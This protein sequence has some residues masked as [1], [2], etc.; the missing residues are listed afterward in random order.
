VLG[1]LIHDLVYP[2]LL[3][4]G[5]F[6]PSFFVQFSN[7][8]FSDPFKGMDFP[9]GNYPQASLGVLVPLSEQNTIP[10]VLD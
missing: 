2:E 5:D 10:L 8:C 4:Y 6:E 3:A 1:G 9:S 7:R